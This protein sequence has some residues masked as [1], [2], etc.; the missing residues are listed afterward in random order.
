MKWKHFIICWVWFV[1]KDWCFCLLKDRKTYS[2]FSSLKG[3]SPLK[4][5]NTQHFQH[6]GCRDTACPWKQRRVSKMFI[7]LWWPAT[8]SSLSTTHQFS[9]FGAAFLVPSPS[10]FSTQWSHSADQFTTSSAAFVKTESRVKKYK[11]ALLCS[12]GWLIKHPANGWRRSTDAERGGAGQR[13]EVEVFVCVC[14]VN[15]KPCG[16]LSRIEK[17]NWKLTVR[18]KCLS[19]PNSNQFILSLCGCLC[20]VGKK[21]YLQAFLRYYIHKEWDAHAD[22]P[23]R[24]EG[25]VKTDSE[26]RHAACVLEIS[27]AP[28][29][30]KTV[31]SRKKCFCGH[32][33]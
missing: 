14:K 32:T 2:H 5:P 24:L 18:S 10:L 17:L 11:N 1:Y 4:T 7:Y 29:A 30:T 12:F 33:R 20:Q 31:A 8:I 13:P 6:F 16:E 3:F 19:P 22:P 25:W 21:K 27:G 26:P 23:L 28:I 9:T 15:T